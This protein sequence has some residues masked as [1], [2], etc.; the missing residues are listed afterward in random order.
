MIAFAMARPDAGRDAAAR[1][2]GHFARA[3]ELS[4]GADAAPYVT[5]AEA[6][7]VPQQRRAEF[8]RLLAQALAVDP[9]RRPEGRLANLVAQR[10]A[11]WLLARAERLFLE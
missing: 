9:A 8:E 10:R 7:C 1:A 3:V 11:R 2:R 6:V 5:L 4:A